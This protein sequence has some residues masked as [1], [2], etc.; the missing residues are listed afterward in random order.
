MVFPPRKVA[1]VAFM[2]D[3]C[4]PGERTLKNSLI[5]ANWEEDHSLLL[6]LSCQGG[7]DLALNPAACHRGLICSPPYSFLLTVFYSFEPLYAILREK[8]TFPFSRGGS[9]DISNIVIS[10]PNRLEALWLFPT[11]DESGMS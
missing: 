7:L 3:L 11:F 8:I 9:N 2:P 1:N 10:C 4:R 6:A 5:Y